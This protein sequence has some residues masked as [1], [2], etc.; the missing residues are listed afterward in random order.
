VTAVAGAAALRW[1]AEAWRGCDVYDLGQRDEHGRGRAREHDSGRCVYQ[2]AGRDQRDAGD[3]GPDRERSARD[4]RQGLHAG[5]DSPQRHVHADDLHRK[6]GDRRHRA[7]RTL[8]HRRAAC[9]R[10]RRGRANAS[11]T[12]GAGT[13]DAKAGAASVALASGSV[14][15]GATCTLSVNVTARAPDVRQHDSGR[16]G[17]QYASASNTT[18]A[19][20]TLSVVAAPNVT[21]AKRSHRP[22]SC[23]TAFRN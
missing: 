14:G 1:A 22:R 7:D 10:E 23:A 11:T 3:R 20:A 19:T 2:R 4:A 6:H 16:H 18:P 17:H 5:H 13:V 8:A 15:A 12:C 9:G 21:I